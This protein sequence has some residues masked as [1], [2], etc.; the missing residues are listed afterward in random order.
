MDV[1]STLVM[2]LVCLAFMID[3]IRG[4][5][6]NAAVHCLTMLPHLHML[7]VAHLL[8]AGLVSYRRYKRK[9]RMLR[10]SRCS[11]PKPQHKRML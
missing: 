10:D 9:K 1:V 7:L 3:R 5:Q 11:D 6:F 4:W 2:L 8:D